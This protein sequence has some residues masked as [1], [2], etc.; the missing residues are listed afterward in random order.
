MR[1]EAWFPA[2]LVRHTEIIP[3]DNWPE[4][5]SAYW[6]SFKQSLIR[7]GVSETVARQASD[8]MAEKPP[9]FLDVHL[10]EFL[11]LVKIVWK[12]SAASEADSS[13][14]ETAERLSRNCTDCGGATGIAV[15]YRQRSAG[16][17]GSDGRPVS[18]TIQCYCMCAMG[19]WVE[20]NHRTRSPEIRR[21]F[22]DLAEHEFLQGAK[23]RSLAPAE[24]PAEPAMF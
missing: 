22:Y 11:A 15:R 24:E 3:R 9:K 5:S 20:A 16:T 4:P 1:I 7:H 21:R 12:H 19:R 14:R 6:Q 2:F 17:V 13:E 10:G 18:P 23:Y 8:L